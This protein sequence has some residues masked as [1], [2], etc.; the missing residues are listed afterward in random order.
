MDDAEAIV[1]EGGLPGEPSDTGAAPAAGPFWRSFGQED[2]RLF[3]ITFGA[4]LAG[5]ITSVIAVAAAGLVFRGIRSTVPTGPN[6]CIA[7]PRAKPGVIPG[8]AY[9]AVVVVAAT[10]ILI[11]VA[12]SRHKHGKSPTAPAV[13]AAAVA[14]FGILVLLLYVYFE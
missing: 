11:G 3:W 5:T 12:R 14:V 13:L 9:F 6:A 7:C 1:T 10:G 4:T 8:W 2:A